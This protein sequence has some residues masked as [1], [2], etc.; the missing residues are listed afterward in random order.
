M[1]KNHLSSVFDIFTGKHVISISACFFHGNTCIGIFFF[2]WNINY[3]SM[4][5]CNICNST[6]KHHL[7]L[8]DMLVTEL[9]RGRKL[10]HIIPDIGL[11]FSQFSWVLLKS[12]HTVKF[13]NQL[14]KK[15]DN[16]KVT[17]K[18]KNRMQLNYGY[19]L[20]FHC[21]INV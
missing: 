4:V 14:S 9:L 13:H 2:A 20:H 21:E 5:I 19:G 15:N 1:E 12:S 6:R 10:L 8:I 17:F 11:R 7:Y 3:A 18:C 16:F